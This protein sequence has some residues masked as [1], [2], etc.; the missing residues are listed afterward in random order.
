MPV[1][2]DQ[3]AAL[4]RRHTEAE[5]RHAEA[6]GRLQGA[7]EQVELLTR[8]MQD[9]YGCA[10]ADALLV[11]TSDAEAALAA[12]YAEAE[13]LLSEAERVVQP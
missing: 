7:R 10:D 8:R 9:E 3:I 12:G 13:R 1:T 4:R 5:R 11:M 6:Q 2:A